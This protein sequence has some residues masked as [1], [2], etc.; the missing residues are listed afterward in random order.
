MTE[1]HYPIDN[2][3][4]LARISEGDEHCFNLIFKKYR[5]QVYGYLLSVTK[6]REASEEMVLDIFLKI[7]KSREAAIEIRDLEAYLF[8]IAHRRAIDFFRSTKR[9]PELQDAIWE[10]MAAVPGQDDA[11][12]LIHRKN[13][14]QLIKEAVNQLSPQRKRV[15][16]LRNL[17]DMSYAEI[18][19]TMQLSSNTVR[20][21]LAAAVQS[22]RAYLLKNKALVL[23][24]S[25]FFEKML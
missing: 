2:A 3:Y 20:N 16:E 8:K 17:E 12:T 7:W 10:A 19:E 11:D 1:S 25:W 14:E 5:D 6:S 13:V 15:F 24:P 22:I 18:G 21:H 4:C 9:S 23:L